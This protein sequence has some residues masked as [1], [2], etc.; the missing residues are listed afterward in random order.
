MLHIFYFGLEVNQS[1]LI[2][3]CHIPSMK[4]YCY[5]LDFGKKEEIFVLEPLDAKHLGYEVG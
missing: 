2:Q 1:Y 5:V 3:I 4:G